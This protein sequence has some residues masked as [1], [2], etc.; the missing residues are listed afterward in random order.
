VVLGEEI[1]SVR[2]IWLETAPGAEMGADHTVRIDRFYTVVSIAAVLG[3]QCGNGGGQGLH[4]VVPEMNFPDSV[5][6][7]IIPE[8]M[9]Q[10]VVEQHISAT[11]SNTRSSGEGPGR[12]CCCFQSSKLL[13]Q[14]VQSSGVQQAPSNQWWQTRRKLCERFPNPAK[15]PS[16][17]F[18]LIFKREICPRVS[19]GN[20]ATF[21]KEFRE[22]WR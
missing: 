4:V 6:Y 12:G 21:Y 8:R 2:A 9:L 5:Q 16:A 20:R 3:S 7:H 18:G 19:G 14:K 10:V 22:R 17:V 13:S 15:R 1:G 11:P